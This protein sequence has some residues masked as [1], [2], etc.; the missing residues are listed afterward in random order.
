MMIRRKKAA[1]AQLDL[2]VST[3]SIKI[4]VNMGIG[5]QRYSVDAEIFGAFAVHEPPKVAGIEPLSGWRVS[6][7]GTGMRVAHAETRDVAVWAARELDAAM[8]EDLAAL[9]WGEQWSATK[10]NAA[11]TLRL[12]TTRDRVQAEIAEREAKKAIAK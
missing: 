5:T 8:G 3:T 7:V 6:H 10:A 12:K 2:A 11:K 1:T 9:K 4:A